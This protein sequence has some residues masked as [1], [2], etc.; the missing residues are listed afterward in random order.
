MGYN[1]L[2]GVTTLT[3]DAIQDIRT[4]S[5]PVFSTTYLSG[6]NA[7]TILKLDANRKVVGVTSLATSDN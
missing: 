1:P 4:G 7:N 5:T 3:I 2:S 6:Q